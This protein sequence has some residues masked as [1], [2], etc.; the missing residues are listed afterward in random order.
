MTGLER[1]TPMRLG[2]I[3]LAFAGIA[4]VAIWRPA[5]VSS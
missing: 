1:L 4:V 5:R 2:G 3:A